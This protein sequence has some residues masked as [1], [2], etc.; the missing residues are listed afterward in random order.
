MIN[1]PTLANISP[2]GVLTCLTQC[3]LLDECDDV[4]MSIERHVFELRRNDK[5]RSRDCSLLVMTSP[6]RKT[7][8]MV[9]VIQ[10]K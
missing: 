1:A 5:S 10:V 6:F 2:E 3:T 9:T 4:R 7:M 8:M